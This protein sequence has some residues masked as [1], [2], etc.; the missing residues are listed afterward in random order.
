MRFDEFQAAAEAV[1]AEIPDQYKAGVDALVVERKAL[2]HPTIRDIY[3]LGE[4]LTETWPS[5]YHGPETLRSVLVLYYGSFLRLSRLDPDFDWDEELWETVTHELR[6]HL[7]SLAADDTLEDVDYAAD[8]NF[9]RLEG[10]PF[11]PYFFRRGEAVAPGLYTVERDVFVEV[12]A[13]RWRPGE[14]VE[15]DIGRQRYRVAAP[16]E[17]GDVCFVHLVEGVDAAGDVYLVLTRRPT[18]RET[19]GA[20][21]RPRRPRVV[22]TEAR[23]ERVGDGRSGGDVAL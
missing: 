12:E 23:A 13:R 8:E 7:E 3:T 17:E 5:D 16:A 4:C 10:E 6:H 11:D 15:F 9:K 1:W 20:L 19:L 18:L 2:A 21:V 14:P 22:E